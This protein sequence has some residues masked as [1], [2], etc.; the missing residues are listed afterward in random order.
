MLYIM[1]TLSIVEKNKEDELFIRPFN[2]LDSRE[3]CSWIKTEKDLKMIS[4]ELGDKLTSSILDKWVSNSI[5]A[6]VCTVSCYNPLPI[7]FCTISKEENNRLP[8]SSV[9][10]CHFIVSPNYRNGKISRFLLYSAIDE[11][12]LLGYRN[13][14]W[15]IEPS[16][17]PALNMAESLELCEEIT[18]KY[19][20]LIPGFRWFQANIKNEWEIQSEESIYNLQ[21]EAFVNYG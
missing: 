14:Y 19:K 3:I 7:A 9:E 15:R 18:G 20:W 13:I 10:V 1:E 8:P 4:G 16:N 6:F 21:E 17:K 5:K 11:A 2:V 12:I